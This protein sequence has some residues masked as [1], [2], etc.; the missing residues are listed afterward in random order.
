MTYVIFSFVYGCKKENPVR[1]FLSF[2][3]NSVDFGL[4]C[5]HMNYTDVKH[6]LEC[7][8]VIIS[9]SLNVFLLNGSVSAT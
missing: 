9:M 2:V 1:M 5:N 7:S 4:I 3:C 8:S 6:I